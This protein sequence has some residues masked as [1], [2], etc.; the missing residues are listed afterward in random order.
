[1]G[2]SRSAWLKDTTDPVVRSLEQRIAAITGLDLRPPYAEYLQVVNYGLG[3]HYEP[4]FDHATVR[5]LPGWSVGWCP[6]WSVGWCPGWFLWA[7]WDGP[8]GA[9]GMVP[10]VVFGVVPG[11]FLEMGPGVLLGW[12]PGEVLGWS[13]G[14][15]P[16]GSLGCSR[17]CS[18][19]WTLGWSLGGEGRRSRHGDPWV[20]AWDI[21]GKGAREGGRR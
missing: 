16:W 18:W 21:P 10:G 7:S 3:G 19:R 1:M 15:S 4:H 6:G 8:W 11:M 14:V 5:E 9:P 13:L 20:G 17:R 2:C 12:C